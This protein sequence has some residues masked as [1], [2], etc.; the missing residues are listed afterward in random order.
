MI[1]HAEPVM[2]TVFSFHLADRDG[3][4]QAL[5]DALSLLHEVDERFSPYLPA[6]EVSRLADGR[7]AETNV[8]PDVREVLALVDHA[9]MDSDGAFDARR[10]RADGRFDPSGLVKG[11]AVER[12]A[13]KI[14]S[15]V[16]AFA[17]DAGGDVVATTGPSRPKPWRIGVRHPDRPDRVAA[18]LQIDGGAVATSAAYERGAHILDPRDGRVPSDV[19]S[20]TVVGPDMTWADTFATAAYVMGRD[21]LV[22]V[23]EHPGYDAL[24][25][26][27]DDA[28]M[29]TQGMDSYLLR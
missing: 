24:A 6:S 21:G 23:A 3:G 18:V 29:W 17:I 14:S 20:M 25:I 15:V 1:V 26:T 8:H 10:W 22:W 5:R 7:L 13:R 2:G 19:R 12:A 27:W 4:S 16:D 9:A 11:W 28:L